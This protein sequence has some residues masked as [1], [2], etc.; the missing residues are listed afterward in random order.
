MSESAIDT[1]VIQLHDDKIQGEL[2]SLIERLVSTAQAK[3]AHQSKA[4]VADSIAV[5]VAARDR[6]IENVSFEQ[7]RAFNVV[8]YIDDRE[9]SAVTS[10]TNEEAIER[11]VDQAISI[12]KY[13]KPDPCNG[14][15]DAKFLATEFMDLDRNHP[16][17]VEVSQLKDEALRADAASLDYDDCIVPS[18]GSD[19]S[20]VATCTV[21]AN[22]MGFL[23]AS[24]HTVYGISATAIARSEAGM[25]SDYWYD[26]DCRYS[27]ISDP[28]SIGKEA[29]RRAKSHLDPQQVPTGTYPVMFDNWIAP[30]FF[31]SLLDGITG[32]NLYRQESYLQDSLGKQVTAD[33]LTLR[34][35]P[36]I[37]GRLQSR[38]C[39][40]DGV[41]AREK[42]II[43]KGFVNTYLLGIYSSR[44]LKMDPT[45]NAGGVSNVHVEA[46]TTPR[47]TLLKEMNRGLLVTSLIGSATNLLTGNYS[48]GAAGFW[49]ENGEIAY[50]VDNVT[51]A[52]T[53]ESMYKGVIGYGDDVQ[54]RTSIRTG[55]ILVESMTVASN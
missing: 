25:Q 48:R 31:S 4:S 46:E 50:P 51:I 21:T 29:A 9:G 36:Q 47:Q 3:G 39:D 49:V 1:D 45:G 43:D 18:Y 53:L 7:T 35:Y 30:S 12:A 10:D 52:A 2:T 42:T 32:I 44:R 33:S 14:L 28:E 23:N 41:I 24:R 26:Q 15:P 34:E 54:D 11:T 37:P 6:D 20:R 8:V 19:S 38:N 27:R 16:Q 55:S 5:E 22:S 13:T 40:S 17:A